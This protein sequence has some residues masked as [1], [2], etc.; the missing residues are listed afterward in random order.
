MKGSSICPNRI[1][2]HDQASQLLWETDGVTNTFRD[3][4]S[5]QLQAILNRSGTTDFSN[6]F[7]KSFV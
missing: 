1:K 5:L 3:F 7:V 2:D 6:L 4:A